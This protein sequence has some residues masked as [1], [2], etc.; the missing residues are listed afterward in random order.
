MNCAIQTKV[1]KH[2]VFVTETVKISWS[3]FSFKCYEVSKIHEEQRKSSKARGFC[4]LPL[5]A[6]A[7][8]SWQ[9]PP[10]KRDWTAPPR[11]TLQHCSRSQC[12]AQAL[13]GGSSHNLAGRRENT[14]HSHHIMKLWNVCQH[15]RCYQEKAHSLLYCQWI[16]GST[17][18]FS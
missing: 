9:R 6:K 10:K 4:T 5:A 13:C 8:Q 14:G 17:I 15:G 18:C 2:T 11:T 16:C 12:C 7:M 1:S 3:D